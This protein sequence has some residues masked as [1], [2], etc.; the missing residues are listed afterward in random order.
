[1]VILIMVIIMNIL[2]TG[3]RSNIGY[4]LGKSL[5]LRGHIV[6]AGC[7]TLKEKKALEEKINHE[8]IIMFPVVLNLLDNDFNIIDELDIDCLILHAS[9]GNGGS[10]LEISNDRF[11]E[12][13]D[14]NIKG[15]FRLLQK[16]LRYCYYHKRHGKVF[17]TSS[18][19]V[20]YPLP[21]LSTYTS[22][23]LYLVSLAN[24][25]KLELL[26][27][28]LDV[29]ISLILPGAYYTGFN[30][31]MIDNKS[32]DEYIVKD[33]ALVMTKYQKIIFSLLE[34][35]DYSDLVK[36]VVREIEKD[37]PKFIISRPFSQKIFTKLYVLIKTF[38]V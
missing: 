6:Y 8:K 23:K 10:I 33:K 1:M 7:K 25:L 2:I 26:Y 35:I 20:F 34:E 36:E 21:Y 15:N 31:L 3:A 38:I 17:I 19:A 12:V 5:A 14:V 37:K 22:S 32:K 28:G 16:Y 9:I 24:T 4:N 18:L 27:Q 11:N 30:D 13:I 29:S